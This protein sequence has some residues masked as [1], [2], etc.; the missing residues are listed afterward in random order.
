[1][2]DEIKTFIATRQ[3]APPLDRD[4]IVAATRKIA[5][6]RRDVQ[7]LLDDAREARNADPD[8]TMRQRLGVELQTLGALVRE[9]NEAAKQVADIV[10]VM[11]QLA[12][13]EAQL[14]QQLGVL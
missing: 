8:E 14:A 5:K 13:T 10:P 2:A 6:L 12:V 11:D 4:G 9:L 7:L 1:M 3:T